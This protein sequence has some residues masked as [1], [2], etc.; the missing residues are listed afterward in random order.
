[1]E[2]TSVLDVRRVLVAGDTIADLASGTNAGAAA[3]V[4]V[5]TGAVA[6]DVLAAE[7]HTHLL[8]SVAELPELVATL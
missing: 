8:P 1:M 6:L 3:V 7:P 2:R 4:G 5:G